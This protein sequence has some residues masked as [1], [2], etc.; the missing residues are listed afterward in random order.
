MKNTKRKINWPAIKE[1]I[2]NAIKY[3]I[4]TTVMVMGFWL[5]YGMLWNLLS[6][7]ATTAAMWLLFAQALISEHIFIRWLTKQKD[8]EA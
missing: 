1:R 3:V 6:F 5:I 2:V 7:P 8:K 4:F